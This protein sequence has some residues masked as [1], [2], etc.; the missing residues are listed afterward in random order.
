MFSGG[1]LLY[2]TTADQASTDVP[3]PALCRMVNDFA[4]HLSHL[5]RHWTPTQ[6]YPMDFETAEQLMQ[7]RN[8]NVF[9]HCQS[10]KDFWIFNILWWEFQR[11]QSQFRSCHNWPQFQDDRGRPVNCRLRQ[12]TLPS[13]PGA[14]AAAAARVRDPFLTYFSIIPVHIRNFRMVKDEGVE[15]STRFHF[16][17][18]WQ[19]DVWCSFTIFLGNIMQSQGFGDSTSQEGC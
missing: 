6:A 8:I 10:M 1:R 18:C 17:V 14:G 9:S 5:W 16:E 3:M 13:C 11:R 7:Q 2:P 4:K 19:R 15:S 12:Q